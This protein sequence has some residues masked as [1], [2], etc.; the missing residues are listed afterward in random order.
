MGPHSGSTLGSSLKGRDP[1]RLFPGLLVV[2][3]PSEGGAPSHQNG[4]EAGAA[5]P[6]RL[7]SRKRFRILE[8]VG[9]P[10]EGLELIFQLTRLRILRGA[11]SSESDSRSRSSPDSEFLPRGAA[12]HSGRSRG[13]VTGD[14]SPRSELRAAEFKTLAGSQRIPVLSYTRDPRPCWAVSLSFPDPAVAPKVYEEKI[15][16]VLSMGTYKAR[17]NTWL[18]QETTRAVHNWD[19][20]LPCHLLVSLVPLRAAR[21][22][23]Q[24]AWIQLPAWVSPTLSLLV[25][26]FHYL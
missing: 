18:G 5:F 12:F 3:F 13:G 26:Q 19:F 16:C 9:G 1:G 11:V 20:S 10:W 15:A 8:S 23:S 24:V 6:G 21:L 14:A 25:P 7:S 4:P 22:C 2:G 17:I